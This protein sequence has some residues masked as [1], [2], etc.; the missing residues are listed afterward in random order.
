M[1]ADVP[2]TNDLLAAAF[3][4]M[5]KT[6]V[7]SKSE[8]DDLGQSDPEA[9]L[10]AQVLSLGHLYE[11][12]YKWGQLGGVGSDLSTG[13]VGGDVERIQVFVKTLTGNTKEVFISTGST[14]MALKREIEKE[15]NWP[16]EQQRLIFADEQLENDKTVSE[17]SI[18]NHSVLHI[19][20]MLRGGGNTLYY[21]DNTLL[22]PSFDYDFTNVTDGSTKFYRGQF[23]YT[24]PCG[25]QRKA[26]K[27]IGQY[28]DDRWLGGGGIRTDT[29]PGEWPVSY[30]SSAVSPEGNI[31][32]VGSQLSRGKPFTYDHGI[33]ST[34]LATVAAKFAPTFD[35]R[36]QKY[37]VIFQNR[38]NPATL[39]QVNPGGA[40]LYWASPEEEDVRPYNICLKR[41]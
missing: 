19:V 36:G 33:F 30:H 16:A 7:I 38:I 4:S 2:T 15:L 3:S 13:A 8:Y 6:R 12:T 39:Q 23:V 1:S 28:R 37:Q 5:L 40:E 24:R 34:P 18:S 11:H 32:E 22:A 29:T 31:A 17:Y 20:M 10:N 14:I 35:Y 27:V 21:L 25:W 9:A 41:V 26:M